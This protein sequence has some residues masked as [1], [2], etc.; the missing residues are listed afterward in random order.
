MSLLNIFKRKS[1]EEKNEEEKE[2]L[3]G[4][5][6]ELSEQI[7]AAASNDNDE[8]ELN[9][10]NEV[11]D[12]SYLSKEEYQSLYHSST[13]EETVN[14]H[15]IDQLGNIQFDDM[16][17][18]DTVMDSIPIEDYGYDFNPPA[19]SQ[20]EKNSEEPV[21]IS[22]SQHRKEYEL[23]SS[24]EYIQL[25]EYQ[26]IVD[27]SKAECDTEKLKKYFSLK[28]HPELDQETA[29][30][31]AEK[32]QK[33]VDFYIN[34]TDFQTF[35]NKYKDEII[36]LEAEAVDQLKKRY[37]DSL[38]IDY[39]EAAEENII[40]YLSEIEEKRD[41][42]IDE[43]QTKEIDRYQKKLDDKKKQ[44]D[45]ELKKFQANQESEYNDYQSEQ[46][47]LKD[48]NI[49]SF[50]ESESNKYESNKA[51]ALDEEIQ[52]QK[53]EAVKSL[54][55][56]K[57]QTLD[58]LKSKLNNAKSEF[59]EVLPKHIEH[60]NKVIE[61]RESTWL[62]E[63]TTKQQA[64][65]QKRQN[66]YK[67]EEI[68]LIRDKLKL[69]EAELV[70]RQSNDIKELEKLREE[71]KALKD[72]QKNSTNQNNQQ[73]PVGQYPQATMGYDPYLATFMDKLDRKVDQ[74]SEKQKEESQ[75]KQTNNYWLPAILAILAI[76]AIIITAFA[77]T[78]IVKGDTKAENAQAVQTVQPAQA[79]IESSNQGQANGN[80]GVSNPQP[81][82]KIDDKEIKKLFMELQK[83]QDFKK[84]TESQKIDKSLDERVKEAKGVE[85][86]DLIA[87]D[88]RNEGNLS[89]LKKFNESYDSNYGELDQKILENDIWAIYN[90][91]KEAPSDYIKYLGKERRFALSMCL[92]RNYFYKVN[93]DTLIKD[94]K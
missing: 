6:D 19:V 91:L 54:D 1:Q 55:Y 82:E 58:D 48:G 9:D 81:E 37:E 93:D 87:N 94:N 20:E 7:E 67:Q 43:Y 61:E 3:Y 92:Y 63:I 69:R 17:E 70:A 60:F 56:D 71:I 44:Q 89:D 32:E 51:S 83:D 16:Q 46:E 35:I 53:R 25:T 65:E 73:V 21:L 38:A 57:Q 12:D 66:D 75:P 90:I 39:E 30:A 29:D 36:D 40:D 13:E 24:E 86:Y 41:Q 45:L 72:E 52:K 33:W 15:Q 88:L 80:Q 26:T 64:E 49:Q 11:D 4:I 23:P 8:D 2:S 59:L 50:T 74:L 77:T 42:R 47:R 31:L 5:D 84:P 79:T 10:I 27:D 68:Q 22:R 14:N 85:D 76:L 62:H 34:S 78:Y 18:N 28:S